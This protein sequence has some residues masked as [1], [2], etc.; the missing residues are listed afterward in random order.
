MADRTEL[1]W[2]CFQVLLQQDLD[3][4]NTCV[5]AANEPVV[6]KKKRVEQM[7]RRD[8]FEQRTGI[9]RSNFS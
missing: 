8:H 2:Q 5:I 7:L 6:A 3:V 9:P 1:P 4:W